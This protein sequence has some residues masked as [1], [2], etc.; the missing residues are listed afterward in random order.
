[1]G[2]TRRERVQSP[3]NLVWLDLEMTGLDPAEDVIIQAALI[4]T[5]P[6]LKPLEECAVDIWQPE[7]KLAKMVPFV[8]EM[9][10]KTGLVER[11][12]KSKIDLHAAEKRLLERVTGWCAFPAI[13]CGNSVGQDKRFVE[14]WMPGLAGY[15]SYRLVD[16]TSIKVLA[17]LW[18]GEQA[19]Y[20]KPEAG[21]HDALVDIQNSIAELA[22]Y[23]ASLFRAP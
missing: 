18:Y 3:G 1:M 13:L 23:R 4:V 12:R 21:E 6:E 19:V 17:R 11:V 10:E 16:V 2:E 15:L 8:R 5:D 9:H 14:R 20:Q 22:H 7:E